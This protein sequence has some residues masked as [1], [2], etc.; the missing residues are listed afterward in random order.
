MSFTRNIQCYVLIRECTILLDSR[1]LIRGSVFMWP[2]Q[3]TFTYVEAATSRI[4]P[5]FWRHLWFLLLSLFVNSIIF[6][7][8][9]WQLCQAS[10]FIFFVFFFFFFCL[11]YTAASFDF[12]CFND[13]FYS[14]WLFLQKLFLNGSIWMKLGALSA[15]NVN[16]FSTCSRGEHEYSC[17]SLSLSLWTINKALNFDDNSIY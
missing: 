15:L 1:V 3:P 10:S 14:F 7:L 9:L 8:R 13:T 6:P 2:L 4:N 16:Y 11:S 12:L 17:S 5:L